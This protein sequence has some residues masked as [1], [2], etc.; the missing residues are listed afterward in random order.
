MLVSFY[1]N[2]VGMY[3][4]RRNGNINNLNSG[5][6]TF[7]G[8]VSKKV[9]R[10]IQSRA[11]Y[12][13]QNKKNFTLKTFTLTYKAFTDQTQT[14][15]HLNRFL[16]WLKKPRKKDKWQ[17]VN[18]YLYVLEKTKKGTIHYHFIIDCQIIDI[19]KIKNAWCKAKGVILQ[20][21]SVGGI[22]RI[23]N[24]NHAVNYFTKYLTKNES[25]NHI[26]IVHEYIDN[27]GCSEYSEVKKYY[28]KYGCDYKTARAKVNF[29]FDLWQLEQS[30]R[31]LKNDIFELID[32]C[33]E[34]KPPF[35]TEF[36]LFFD[37]QKDKIPILH[38]NFT[39]IERVLQLN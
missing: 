2:G 39:K 32:N 14:K 33:I 16:T 7:R 34:Q 35:I 3:Y 23:N 22:K 38:Q 4:Q 1:L 27:E 13:A 9:K 12:M 29:R 25:D 6:T 31:Y 5:R 26:S 10:I 20:W 19:P 15:K 8:V 28:R 30:K 17:G 37:L 18:S 11:A 21:A 24:T 36:V